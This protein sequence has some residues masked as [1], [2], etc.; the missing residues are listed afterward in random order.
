MIIKNIY[1]IFYINNKNY[2]NNK[3]IIII[4]NSFI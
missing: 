3:I 1:N 2:Y 4:I